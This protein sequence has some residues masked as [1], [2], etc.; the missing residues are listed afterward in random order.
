[1]NNSSSLSLLPTPRYQDRVAD[2]V[3]FGDA[4]AGAVHREVMVRGLGW[5][6]HPNMELAQAL[7]A[8]GLAVVTIDDPAIATRKS[9]DAVE[10]FVRDTVTAAARFASYSDATLTGV[11]G[12]FVR[13]AVDE[14]HWPLDG[15]VLW[16]VDA[17]EQWVADGVRGCS[18]GT[19]RN[20]RT[21]LLAVSRALMPSE[22]GA[23]VSALNTKSTSRP[24]SS[25]EMKAHRAW[26]MSQPAGI[27]RHRA[28]LMLTL[29][30]GAGLHSREVGLI[31]HADVQVDDL[32][33]FIHV[34]GD[35]PRAVPLAKEWE[36][37]M[38]KVMKER[39]R[40][41]RLWGAGARKDDRKLLSDFTERAVG[42]SPSGQRL[43]N[44]WIVGHLVAEVPIQDLMWAAGVKK[45][46]HL[47]TYFQFLPDRLDADYRSALR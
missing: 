27:K 10:A 12:S 13:W 35:N 14:R 4:K 29:C 28:M 7:H 47:S 34:R 8:S 18:E 42:S 17:I 37:W 2:I 33:I 5:F 41:E 9:V 15:A 24:Y 38:A 45:F 26:A 11:V 40:D 6:D 44:T 20:R 46:E 36:R 23:K 3:Q 16:T 1:M 32:G 21:Q 30:G 25:E 39:P 43:R 31:E 19:V 22:H